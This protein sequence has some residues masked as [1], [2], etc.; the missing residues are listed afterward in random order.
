[1]AKLKEG[2]KGERA[3]VMPGLIVAELENDPFESTLHIT[4]IGYYPRAKYHF[5]ERLQGISQYVLIYCIE[6]EGWFKLREKTY[7][8]SANQFCIL[9]ANIPHSYGSNADNPW[10][11]YWLHF[12]GSLAGFYAE[13]FDTPTSILPDEQS[14]INDRLS[15]FEEIYHVLERGYSR[16]NVNFAISGLYYFLGTIKYISKFRESRN[17]YPDSKDIVERATEYMK[18]NLEKRTLQLSELCKHLGYSESHF[19]L[20]FKKRTG[21]SP[22]NYMLHLKIQSACHMLDFSDMKIS[23]IC[24]KIGIADPYYFSR[25]F[26]KTMGTSPTEYRKNK[27]G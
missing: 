27:K 24:H 12:K 18:E 17:E 9:P 26:T 19:S 7:K 16:E 5:R 6:G 21:Y 15:V 4:D 13:G 1:M 20:L 11:I 25:L 22:I 14:R 3:I 8:V 2:F 10:T 23:Q